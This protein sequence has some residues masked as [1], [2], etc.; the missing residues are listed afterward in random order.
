[1]NIKDLIRRH[2]LFVPYVYD[3]AT[4]KEITKGSIV[5]GYP[6][7]GIGRR[8]DKA[9][10]ISEEEGEVLL[11]NDLA[12]TVAGLRQRFAWFD[13]LDSVRQCVVID[14]ALNLGVHGFSN[15]RRMIA[16]IEKAVIGEQD[17]GTVEM[18]MADS[19]WALQVGRRAEELRRMM[20]TGEW[21]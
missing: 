9:N 5:V 2:E 4:G 18:E 3:D 7:I 13:Q 8:C 14:M 17:W 6:T 20:L 19:D 11:D 16:A 1:M 21:I 15:F 12:R 10:G